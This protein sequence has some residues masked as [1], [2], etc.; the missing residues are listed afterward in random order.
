MAHEV[1][2]GLHENRRAGTGS[3][4]SFPKTDFTPWAKNPVWPKTSSARRPVENAACSRHDGVWPAFCGPSNLPEQNRTMALFGGRDRADHPLA[5]PQEAKRLLGALA[6]AEPH[7]ALTEVIQWIESVM[8]AEDFRQDDRATLIMQLDESGQTPARKLLREYLGSERLPKQEESRLWKAGHEFWNQLAVAY[9]QDIDSSIDGAKGSDALK[10]LL[11][12]LGVRTMHALANQLKWLQ[13]RYGPV[14]GDLWFAAGRTYRHLKSKKLQQKMVPVYPG[15]PGESSVEQEFLKLIMFA[16]SS[17]DSLVPAEVE[18]VDRV[19]DYFLPNF[20]LTDTPKP[21]TTY[22]MDLDEAD[23]PQRLAQP[24]ELTDTLVFFSAGTAV[25]AVE[26]L[27]RTI[28][29]KQAVPGE[30]KLGMEYQPAAVIGML[31]HLAIYWAKT[32]PIRKHERRRVKARLSVVHGYAGLM[33]CLNWDGSTTDLSMRGDNLVESWVV[34]NVSAGGFGATTPTVAGDWL[35][36]GSVVGMQPSGSE[37]WLVGVVRRLSRDAEELGN[38]GIQTIAK[39]ARAVDLR[40]GGSGAPLGQGILLSDP[41]DKPGELRILLDVNRFD[42]RR[43]IQLAHE[44]GY[45]LTPVGLIEKGDGYELAKYR[46]PR[47]ASAS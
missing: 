19:I 31:E 5:D 4:F 9:M 27:S 35:K 21:D 39:S 24:P 12:A 36:I 8:S 41:S 16:A 23:A 26:N 18:L 33:A 2:I 44:T 22:W 13:L 11:P 45:L 6:T 32:P 34:Q 29:T 3:G 1:E 20:S 43:S 17:P 40:T 37:N 7:Q 25:Q 28:E 46:D 38:V 30:L 42:A 14:H 10:N 15:V 47:R